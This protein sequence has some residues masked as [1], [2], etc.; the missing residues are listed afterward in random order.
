MTVKELSEY[1]RL[2]R[3]TIYKMLKE[4]SI[5][6]SRIGHQWRFFREDIDE[7]IRSLRTGN[8]TSVLVVDQDSGVREIFDSELPSEAFDVVATES[9]EESLGLASLRQFDVVFMEL[10]RSTLDTFKQVRKTNSTVPVVILSDSSDGKLVGQAMEI[11][12]FTLARKPT[13]G[14]D[15]RNLLQLLSLSNGQLDI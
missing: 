6:A 5:P 15:V 7:W 3:M 11:G 9:A 14:T 4:G 13:S 10:A 12:V 1:L 8:R 2:D